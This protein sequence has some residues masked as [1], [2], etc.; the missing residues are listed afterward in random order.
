MS[1]KLPK[2]AEAAFSIESNAGPEFRFGVM[3]YGTGPMGWC[4]GSL[5]V[6]G[7]EP[8]RGKR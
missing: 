6:Y 5:S 7:R 2:G 1:L 4:M 3:V 8:W